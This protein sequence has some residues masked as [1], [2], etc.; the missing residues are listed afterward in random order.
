[1]FCC[2]SP[3]VGSRAAPLVY[4]LP[5]P[6]G[7]VLPL[8]LPLCLPACGG[9]RA[10]HTTPVHWFLRPTPAV[11]F[12]PVKRRFCPATCQFLVSCHCRS[13]AARLARP[14]MAHFFACR[15]TIPRARHRCYRH[16]VRRHTAG[17]A[18]L[19]PRY[20]PVPR[21]GVS[22]TAATLT[23]AYHPPFFFTAFWIRCRLLRRLF[24]EQHHRGTLLPW[25]A[26]PF[27]MPC[28]VL[29]TQCHYRT[30]AVSAPLLPPFCRSLL[31][32]V[33]LP[34]P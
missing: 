22:Y 19:R 32:C 4:N 3:L 33:S 9:S 18:G 31:C 27:P 30:H 1:M 23:P 12:K 17:C 10:P 28:R 14:T 13:H 6:G 29:L 20:L 24:V 21:A 26:A 11:W 15:S 34:L 7:S 5:Y 8:R 16:P 25:F 2:C